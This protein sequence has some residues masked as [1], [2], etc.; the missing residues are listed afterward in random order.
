MAY[1]LWRT[2][3]DDSLRAVAR[4]DTASAITAEIRDRPAGEPHRY[5]TA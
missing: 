2:A 3:K 1:E 4:W 5:V